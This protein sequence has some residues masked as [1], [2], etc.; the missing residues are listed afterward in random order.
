MVLACAALLMQLSTLPQSASQILPDAN[1]AA[2]SSDNSGQKPGPPTTTLFA[3][4]GVGSAE[5]IDTHGTGPLADPGPAFRMVRPGSSTAPADAE[6]LGTKDVA[7]DNDQLGQ[8]L[9]T[10]R[11]P[12]VNS[13]QV[14]HI[15]AVEVPSRRGWLSLAIAEHAAATFDAYTTRQAISNGAIENDPLMRP[16]AHSDAM[17]AAVQV[18]PFLFDY[19]ARRMQ[20]SDHLTLRRFWWL[21]QSVSTGVSVF[22]GAHNLHVS[23]SLSK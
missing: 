2:T 4:S 15:K 5:N 23:N 10:V 16:F 18:G 6:T 19:L 22:A 14:N 17:Y 20:S 13:P 12:E 7:L 8:G 21:P 9:S 11:V 3:S 1:Q